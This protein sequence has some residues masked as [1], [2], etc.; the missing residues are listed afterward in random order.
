MRIAATLAAVAVAATVTGVSIA[1]AAGADPGLPGTNCETNMLGA[2]YCD[3]PVQ[4]DGSWDRCVDVYPQP[5]YGGPSGG[6]SG[7]SPPYHSCY[8]YDPAAPPFKLGQPDYHIG[9]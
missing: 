9:L 7:W 3:G 2:L 5:I 8:H 6:V 4:A 1:P